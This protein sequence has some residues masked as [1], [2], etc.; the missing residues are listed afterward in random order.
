MSEIKVL[1]CDHCGAR[2]ESIADKDRFSVVNVNNNWNRLDK[3]LK[4]DLCYDCMC[5]AQKFM[6]DKEVQTI[7]NRGKVHD[8]QKPGG[9]L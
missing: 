8:L 3:P 4:Y 1:R 7:L 5:A 2:A 9:G 6:I